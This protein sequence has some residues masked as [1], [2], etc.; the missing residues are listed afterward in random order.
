MEQHITEDSDKEQLQMTLSALIFLVMKS[1]EEEP[2]EHGTPV[3][4]KALAKR[5]D[6]FVADAKALRTQNS[7]LRDTFRHLYD[8][9]ERLKK[10]VAELEAQH[11]T[12]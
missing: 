12:V 3:D 6:Q 10:R 8:E 1:M 4:L 7:T 11:G 5:L 2:P 9:A